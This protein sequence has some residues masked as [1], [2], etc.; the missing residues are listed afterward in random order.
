M[1]AICGCRACKTQ[2]A[3]DIQLKKTKWQ[4]LRRHYTLKSHYPVAFV[5]YRVVS[6][7]GRQTDCELA[8]GIPG[9]VKVGLTPAG[10]LITCQFFALLMSGKPDTQSV[11]CIGDNAIG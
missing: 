2:A 7:A 5:L 8:E 1:F 4:C 9:C 6:T 3:G 10:R 11:L